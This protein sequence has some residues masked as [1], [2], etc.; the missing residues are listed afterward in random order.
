[1]FLVFNSTI[2]SL[3]CFINTCGFS[4]DNLKREAEKTIERKTFI[5]LREGRKGNREGGERR[6]GKEEK[7][8][9]GKRRKENRERGERRNKRDKKRERLKKSRE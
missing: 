5:T 1:M 9:K 3:P 8:E 7:G 6:I 4:T 2:F